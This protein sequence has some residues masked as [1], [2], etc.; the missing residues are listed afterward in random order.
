MRFQGLKLSSTEAGQPLP[1]QM[2]TEATKTQS[3]SCLNGSFPSPNF[4]EAYSA[5]GEK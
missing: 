4:P 1:W 3:K 5:M 2:L